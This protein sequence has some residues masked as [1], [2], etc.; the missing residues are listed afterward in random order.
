MK[1]VPPE[2]RHPGWKKIEVS[3]STRPLNDIP[4]SI[5]NW[6]PIPEPEGVR[7]LN[8]IPAS[9]LDWE[10]IARPQPPTEFT[11]DF[12]IMRQIAVDISSL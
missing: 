8:N 5:L 2:I 10:P 4:E 3:A 6:T 12:P 7:E 11:W 9:I 1:F